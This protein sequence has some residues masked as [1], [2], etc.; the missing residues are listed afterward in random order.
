MVYSLLWVKVDFL[1]TML[2]KWLRCQHFCHILENIKCFVS[3]LWMR[4]GIKDQSNCPSRTTMV[5]FLL[6]IVIKYDAKTSGI[7]HVLLIRYIPLTAICTEIHELHVYIKLW[8]YLG[9]S[10]GRDAKF[11]ISIYTYTHID[12]HM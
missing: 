2:H 8:I 11:Y 5:I 1:S 6:V 9:I 10:P 4:F 3:L 7:K 12:T